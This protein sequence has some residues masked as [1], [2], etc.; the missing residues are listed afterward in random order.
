MS[1]IKNAMEDCPSC[2][3]IGG[4]IYIAEGDPPIQTCPQCD[5]RGTILVTGSADYAQSGNEK[6][7]ISAEK[8]G[9]CVGSGGET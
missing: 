5:G 9:A 2:D 8:S 1:R 4:P 3:G 6:P 7:P